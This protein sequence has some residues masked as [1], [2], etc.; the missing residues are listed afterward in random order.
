MNASEERVRKLII[1]QAADWFVANRAGLDAKQRDGFAAWLKASPMHVEEYL[2]VSVI[3]RDLRAACEISDG[4]LDA[5]IA[6]ARLEENAPV[7]RLW[8]RPL[9]WTGAGSPRWLQAAAATAALVVCVSLFAWWNFRPAPVSTADRSA[10]HFAT[11]H[12]EQQNYRLPDNSVLYLNS[13]S[14]VTIRY[15]TKERLIVLNAGEA[16]FAVAHEAGRPFKVATGAAEVTAVG[17]KFDVRLNLNSTVITVS[18][19]RVAV[20]PPP[21]GRGADP[22]RYAARIEVGADE[23]V[24]VVPGEWPPAGP[25][26][27]DAQRTTAW[28]RRQIMFDHET[29]ERVT[30]E[31]NRYSPKPIEIAT[32]ALRKLEISGNFATDD[33]AAFIAFLRSLE[34][35]RV[36]ETATHIR[37]SRD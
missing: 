24:K 5:L 9:E 19:G 7:R 13:D 26:A 29:L 18:E 8:P 1:E 3:T 14:A 31:F 16:A 11:G 17:T 22:A 35:V 10:L 32:P 12:G 25:T 30:G 28:L 34:G 4:A 21:D 37:V 6:R 36:E 23:Q 20:A 2:A 27:V 15:G 33:T